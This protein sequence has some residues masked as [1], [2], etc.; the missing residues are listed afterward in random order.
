MIRIKIRDE[1]IAEY[2]N[3]QHNY[4]AIAK[5]FNVSRERIRQILAPIGMP[6]KSSHKNKNE[7]IKKIKELH[8]EDITFSELVDKLG[9]GYRR[10]GY[11]LHRYLPWI[12]F[13]GNRYT[14]EYITE[15]YNKFNGDYHAMAKYFNIELRSL[16][17]LIKRNGLKDKLIGKG[18]YEKVKKV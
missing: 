11:F 4:S 1:V 2:N 8:S 15:T 13:R 17:Q 5:K 14:I 16:R 12:K 7:I 18:N 10:T 9:I 3:G 6:S